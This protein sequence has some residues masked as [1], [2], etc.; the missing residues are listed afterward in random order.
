MAAEMQVICLEMDP[1]GGINFQQTESKG[2]AATPQTHVTQ[3]PTTAIFPT[4]KSRA[5]RASEGAGRRS[6]ELPVDGHQGNGDQGPMN[7]GMHFAKNLLRASPMA[8]WVRVLAAKSWQPKFDSKNPQGRRKDQVV[9]HF[10][11]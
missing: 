11:F 9:L 5:R 2:M 1:H 6:S 4:F 3:S 10:V 7:L 8:Q